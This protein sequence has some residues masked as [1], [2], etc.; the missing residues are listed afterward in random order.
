M[1]VER[2]LLQS[3]PRS[4]PTHLAASQTLTSLVNVARSPIAGGPDETI[5]STSVHRTR[6]SLLVPLPP[7]LFLI[8]FR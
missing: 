4:S 2:T 5:R 7:P 1:P 8:R 6:R 3:T